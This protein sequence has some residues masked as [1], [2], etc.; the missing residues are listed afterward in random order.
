MSRSGDTSFNQNKIAYESFEIDVSE[1]TTVSDP[2]DL[3]GVTPL[4]LITPATLTQGS[5][6]F[7]FSHD[8]TTYYP[9]YNVA[10]SLVTITVATSAA[11]WV[12]LERVDFEGA[13]YIKLVA[14]S[15]EGS[16][17]T[18]IMVLGRA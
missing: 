18:F 13:R 11:H 1:S 9:L 10:N 16:D 7:Q 6:S 5:F 3:Q 4:G 2:V 15:A 17:R 12:G 8:G 14:A